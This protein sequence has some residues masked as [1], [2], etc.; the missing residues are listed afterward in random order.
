MWLIYQ[1]LRILAWPFSALSVAC[2]AGFAAI[3]GMPAKRLWLFPLTL[4]LLPVA[5]GL[6]V[7]AG[8]FYVPAMLFI[9]PAALGLATRAAPEE[10]G[11]RLTLG[12]HRVLRVL[13]WNEIKELRQVFSPP[14]HA[15][16]AVLHSGESVPIDL[17]ERDALAAAL[18]RRGIPFVGL[19]GSKG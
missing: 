1:T 4:L 13:S 8:I 7:L 16:L 10:D 15:Y 2:A 17:V 18:E 9:L 11:V 5:L 14:F 19:D 3:L 12:R 6:A